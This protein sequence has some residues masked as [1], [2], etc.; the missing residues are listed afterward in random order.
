MDCT[1]NMKHSEIKNRMLQE[2][3]NYTKYK[4]FYFTFGCGDLVNAG[5]YAIIIATN[6]DT[7]RTKMH[8]LFG[9]KWAFVYPNAESAGVQKWRLQ[10]IGIWTAD[11]E[12]FP[13]INVQCF[14]CRQSY[15]QTQIPGSPWPPTCCGFC[16]EQRRF[17]LK[18]II[19][20]DKND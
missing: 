13:K 11:T 4:K 3:I 12:E 2:I 18:E 16:G 19:E 1:V 5:K 9:D 8:T 14:S 17:S 15:E 7:A 10:L 6:T 20:D